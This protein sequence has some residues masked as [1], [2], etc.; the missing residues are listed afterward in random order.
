MGHRLWRVVVAIYRFLTT[1]DPRTAEGYLKFLNRCADLTFA[2][3]SA[4]KLFVLAW[5]QG[6]RTL[7]VI[8]L[9]MIGVRYAFSRISVKQEL[10]I[11]KSVFPPGRLPN[12]LQLKDRVQITIRVLGFLALYMLLGSLSDHI[13]FAAAIMT[14]IAVNDFFTRKQINRNISLDFA[15]PNYFP[16]PTESGYQ[17][18]LNRRA[19]VLPY[20][21]D[22]PHLSKEIACSVGCATAWL[23][24]SYGYVKN[25]DLDTTA[26]VILMATLVLNEIVTL[27][28]RIVRFCRLTDIDNDW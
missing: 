9:F 10:E 6:E 19:V 18:I 4:L 2:T 5:E 14:I 16:S 11:A 26:Y 23:V 7:P 15:D 12:H 1:E 25:I 13:F 22:L 28:W 20:L 21:L 24:T 8:L 3:T 17:T 27:Y